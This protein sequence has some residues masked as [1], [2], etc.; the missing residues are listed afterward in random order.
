MGYISDLTNPDYILSTSLMVVSN[1][2]TDETY[3]IYIQDISTNLK[4]ISVVTSSDPI[5]SVGTVSIVGENTLQLSSLLDFDS[6]IVGSKLIVAS[7]ETTTIDVYVDTKNQPDLIEF[8][9]FEFSPVILDEKQFEYVLPFISNIGYDDTQNIISRGYISND[10]VRMKGE[11]DIFGDINASINCLAE[12]L[13]LVEGGLVVGGTTT[14]GTLTIDKDLSITGSII[15]FG[16]SFTC[17]P[18]LNITSGSFVSSSTL[19]SSLKSGNFDILKGDLSLSEIQLSSGVNLNADHNLITGHD[20]TITKSCTVGK[21]LYIR[22]GDLTIRSWLKVNS[23][24]LNIK[25]NDLEFTSHNTSLVSISNGHF[26]EIINN[27]YH[28]YFSFTDYSRQIVSLC[29]TNEGYIQLPSVESFRG[30][31][32]SQQS[33]YPGVVKT[34]FV[35]ANNFWHENTFWSWDSYDVYEVSIYEFSEGTAGIYSGQS[36]KANGLFLVQVHVEMATHHDYP[37]VEDNAGSFTVDC[38]FYKPYIEESE[39]LTQ[40]IQYTYNNTGRPDL[41]SPPGGPISIDFT[42]VC[43]GSSIGRSKAGIYLTAVNNSSNRTVK[44]SS[45]STYITVTRLG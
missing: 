31:S 9:S 20:L 28:G 43:W 1:D 27:D 40:N 38:I 11:V 22:E 12:G 44:I 35:N 37:Y 21:K 42:T 36:P 13:F 15:S 23:G 7:T 14:M 8:Y 29:I 30:V 25:S 6:I 3:K 24:T 18:T 45:A 5:S 34:L 32:E 2:T 17:N 41:K 4:N 33:F 39:I 26:R 16:D 19:L 10:L